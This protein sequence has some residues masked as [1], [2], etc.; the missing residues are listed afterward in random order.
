MPDGR[1]QIPGVYDDVV[2]PDAAEV[3]S[4]A[5]LPFSEEEFLKNEVGATELTGEPDQPVL[6][7]M[8]ARPTFEVHGIAGGF[9]GAGAKT[10]IPA[11]ATAK[12]SM[13]LVPGQDPRKVSRS[14][15]EVGE[16]KY[17]QRHSDK[18][19]RVECGSRYFGRSTS[20]CH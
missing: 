16:R 10:V 14:A 6:A 4:W 12:V 7:R 17:A 2:P 9:T 11:K 5:G 3:E 13:R 15:D 18:C 1:I 20:S 8:W 19:S